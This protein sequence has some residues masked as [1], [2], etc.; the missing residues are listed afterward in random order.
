MTW[1]QL[2]ESWPK[3]YA[4]HFLINRNGETFMASCWRRPIGSAGAAAY[5]P[6]IHDIQ[7]IYAGEIV[8]RVKIKK[9][10]Q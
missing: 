10:R 7:K 5:L 4:Y 6:R 2:R 9:P 1:K 8:A 3:G